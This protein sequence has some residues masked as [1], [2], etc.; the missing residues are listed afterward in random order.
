M[1]REKLYNIFEGEGGQ[2]LQYGRIMSVLI[3]VSLLP[4][5]FKE[6]PSWL[7]VIEWACVAIFIVDYLARWVTADFKLQRGALSFLIYPFTP[8][9]IID[10]VSILPAFIALNPAFRTLRI[11]RL[12]RVLRAFKLV[13]YSKGANA[14]IHAFVKQKSA[15]SVV[16]VLALGYVLI[17]A[18]IIFNVEP[19]TFPSFFEAVYW[20]V[21]S[22]TTVGY[23]DLYPSTEIGRVVAMVSA[24]VGIAIVALPAGIITAGLLEEISD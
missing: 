11:L 14:I 16:V 3:V 20:A 19:D 9:A 13:R 8:M 10:L 24:F 17:S 4:L 12:L 21:V 18:L 7:L 1:N 2:A 5:C 15:L 23:G 22:L 6:P